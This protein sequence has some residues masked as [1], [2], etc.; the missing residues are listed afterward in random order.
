MKANRED[1]LGFEKVQ[2]TEDSVSVVILDCPRFT[3]VIRGAGVFCGH[4]GIL[5]LAWPGSTLDAVLCPAALG[6]STA[7][8]YL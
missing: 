6:S 5:M 2:H 3:G 1:Q 4:K 7:N 8:K